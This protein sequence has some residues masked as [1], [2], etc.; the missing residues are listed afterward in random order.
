V[1]GGAL[2]TGYLTVRGAALARDDH[3]RLRGRVGAVAL[4]WY[5]VDV[6]WILMFVTLYL[7]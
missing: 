6:V 3:G 7:I 2:V 1:A 4:Y 5:F